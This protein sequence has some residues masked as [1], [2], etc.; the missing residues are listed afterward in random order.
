VLLSL[1]F[2]PAQVLRESNGGGELA[3]LSGEVHRAAR[4]YLFT[5]YKWLTLWVAALFIIICSILKTV[6]RSLPRRWGLA[7]LF[8]GCGGSGWRL[9]LWNGRQRRGNDRVLLLHA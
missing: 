5:Q 4:E 9:P 6:R 7:S 1:T 2:L 3:R 8:S